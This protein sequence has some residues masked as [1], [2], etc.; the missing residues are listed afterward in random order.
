MSTEAWCVNAGSHRLEIRA[1]AHLSHVLNEFR[2]LE[3]GLFLQMSSSLRVS[4]CL[5]LRM[6][7]GLELF[8]KKGMYDTTLLKRCYK[9]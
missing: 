8:S 9:G 1:E 7:C 4:D 6:K 5:P 3:R 2:A